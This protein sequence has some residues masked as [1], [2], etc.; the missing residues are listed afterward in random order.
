METESHKSNR[1]LCLSIV[2]FLSCFAIPVSAH[3]SSDSYL[4]LRIESGHIEGRWDIA[5][6]DLEY[7][8]GLDANEDGAITWGELRSS[9]Q[10]VTGY[11]F[12]R[13]QL[14]SGGSSCPIEPGLLQVDEHSDG[15][16]A[17]LWF[18]SD[19]GQSSSHLDIRYGLLFELDPQHRGLLQLD[20]KSKTHTA[21]LSPEQSRQR[22]Q[23]DQVRKASAFF[24]YMNEGIWHIF[25]GYD[26]ILFLFSLLLPSVFC[27]SSA[28]WQPVRRFY[29]AG[30]EVAKIVT[31][32]TLAHSITLSLAVLGF[33]EFP[34]RWVELAIAASVLFAACNNLYPVIRNRRWAVAFGFGL[35]HGLGFANVLEALGLPENMLLLALVA[36]NLGVEI[37]QLA[38]VGAFL[39]LGYAIRHSRGYLI[40][41]V[42]LG[43]GLIALL[44]LFWLIERGLNIRIE[45]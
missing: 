16:Y 31:A 29:P 27:S 34:S 42:R 23:L 32:F 5:L 4:T 43:S 28:G 14:R 6:R 41:G 35:V 3:K 37:G 12:S 15:G 25:L 44:A 10:E 36:F 7:A 24:Q 8:I 9:R 39:P 19:C 22:V 21:V 20:Y 13:L 2:L 26:H 45:F 1:W 17:V 33:I 18:R 11:A 38:I 40:F 30:I